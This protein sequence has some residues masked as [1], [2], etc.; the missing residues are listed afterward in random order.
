MNSTAKEKSDR[1]PEVA[2]KIQ[3][4][5]FTTIE[6]ATEMFP[7]DNIQV[8]PV[9]SWLSTLAASLAIAAVIASVVKAASAVKK[10]EEV[11]SS[12]W[13]EEERFFLLERDLEAAREEEELESDT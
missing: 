3:P 2:V 11:L 4:V 10:L 8:S 1:I 6:V 13:D 5:T 9:V 7:I 12:S